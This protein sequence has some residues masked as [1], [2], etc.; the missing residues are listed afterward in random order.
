M[1]FGTDIVKITFR[2]HWR[3]MQSIMKGPY[4]TKLIFRSIL[5]NFLIFRKGSVSSLTW[6][7]SFLLFIDDFLMFLNVSK[8]AG[9]RHIT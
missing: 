5:I 7:D 4:I 1:K 8:K 2:I 6:L 9:G 3:L